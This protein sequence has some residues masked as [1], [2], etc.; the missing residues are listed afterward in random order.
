[1]EQ[2]SRGDTATSHGERSGLGRPGAGVVLE[3]SQKKNK[4]RKI[5]KKAATEVSSLV[6]G[7]SETEAQ[8]V[9]KA[10]EDGRELSDWTKTWSSKSKKRGK[11]RRSPKEAATEAS[12]PV[13]G[14]SEGQRAASRQAQA[15][16][17]RSTTGRQSYAQVVR[18]TSNSSFLSNSNTTVPSRRKRLREESTCQIR[19]GK[20]WGRSGVGDV[21][22]EKQASQDSEEGSNG[23]LKSGA[24][25][26]G[27]R[28][29]AGSEGVRGR[30]GAIRLDQ[31][32]VI[33]KQE[34]RQASQES[35]GGSDGGLTTGARNLRG[36]ESS[37][38]ASSSAFREVHYR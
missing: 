33:Q 20:T 28:S 35:E 10:F 32:V 4:R 23:S 36:A 16:S 19:V 6:Q 2:A 18:R 21:S 1:M 34:E 31:D 14:I 27:D 7:I 29:P 9:Q 12:R 26:L 5:P 8:R 17:E 37:K 24:R 22:K 11:R 38:Q 13:R 30:S 15:P 3:T 25:D